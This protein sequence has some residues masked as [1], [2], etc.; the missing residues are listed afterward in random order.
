[1]SWDNVSL[2]QR[3][4]F[5]RALKAVGAKA[6]W[7]IVILSHYPLDFTENLDKNSSAKT[8]GNILKQYVDGGSVTLSGMTVSFKDSNSAKIYAAF[9]G[10]THNFAVAKLSDVQDSGNTEFDVLRIATPNMCYF[11]QQRAWRKRGRGLERH[12]VRRGDDIRKKRTT[13]PTIRPL[14]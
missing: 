14:S 5:A 1:M 7:G 13:R 11:L 4:W 2:T 10:H 9:H 12:R 3:L 6:G 8:L